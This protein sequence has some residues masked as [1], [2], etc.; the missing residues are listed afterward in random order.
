MANNINIHQLPI[1][2][3]M[4]LLL[5][6]QSIKTRMLDASGQIIGLNLCNCG[7]D[8]SF[9][10]QLNELTHLQA[11]N[12]SHNAFKSIELSDE[13]TA[14]RFV[15]FSDCKNL[16]SLKLPNTATALE[17]LDVSD[18]ALEELV[19]PDELRKLVYLDA[20][21]NKLTQ[22]ELPNDCTNLKF[23][24][25]SKNNISALRIIGDFS[26]LEYLYLPDNSMKVLHI[27]TDLP[28]LKL[29]HISNN[30]L[31]ALPQDIIL[32]PNLQTLYAGNNRP[33]NIPDLFLGTSNAENCLEAARLWFTEIRDF[34]TEENKQV[35]LMITG[36]GNTG[37]S[38]LFCAL[39]HGKCTCTDNHESTHGIQIGHLKKGDVQ[40]NVWDFG[41]QEIYHGTHRLFMESPAV[42]VIVFD[43][44]T[45][46]RAVKGKRERD[47]RS[48]E[49]VLDHVIEHW[50]DTASSLSP[51]SPFIVV[52]NKSDKSPEEHDRIR[53]YAKSKQAEFEQISARKGARI[54]NL[55]F[56]LKKSAEQLPEFLMLMPESWL[57]V[58]QWLSDNL[59]KK[60][61][62]KTIKRIDFDAKCE[63]F[64][65][66]KQCWDLLF[67]YL[68][69]SGFLYSHPNLGDT[70][71]IDQEWALT[72]IYKILDRNEDHFKQR[73]AQKRGEISAYE[74]FEIFGSDYTDAEKRLFLQFMETCGICFKINTKESDEGFSLI[75]SYLFP[76]FLPDT[77]HPVSEADWKSRT[78]AVRTLRYKLPY[79][80]HSRLL[81]FITA[82]GR[83]TEIKNIWRNGIQIQT[84]DG[85][86]R[87][88]MD[89]DTPAFILSIEQKAMTTW[90]KPI[91][92][93][94]DRGIHTEKGWEILETD[95]Q[96][97]SVLDAEKWMLK[98]QNF[99]ES[100]ATV[101][102]KTLT[103]I[104]DVEQESFIQ[105]VLVLSANPVSTKKL[106]ASVEFMYLHEQ[107]KAIEN[108]K[109]KPEFHPLSEVTRR[110]MIDRIKELKPHFI[111]FVGHGVLEEK[112]GEYVE[113]LVF[114]NDSNIREPDIL[115]T[116]QLEAT[117]QDI[118][119]RY[120][121]KIPLHTI[122]LNACLSSMQAKAISNAGF[123]V[124]GASDKII[125]TAAR[126]IAA[127]FYKTYR[128]TKDVFQSIDIGLEYA[129]ELRNTFEIYQNGT[130]KTL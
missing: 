36:N 73:K 80:S 74:M 89:Y 21:R 25:L 75:D 6:H 38:T 2:T 43:P 28:K 95:G 62:R 97:W 113:G 120:G 90:L 45:E 31:M 81:S 13:L 86:F 79:P 72:A 20:S 115:D 59:D 116:G 44:T 41:G 52:Q 54:D 39:Q 27:D 99:D 128:N 4:A 94:L 22:L 83:K 102:Q 14:L 29:L 126:E 101:T 35:K 23:I 108:E 69:H 63:E 106:S 125:S 40:F 16:R 3:D 30:Q 84:E 114:H 65:V 19:L 104:E 70:I 42:Q 9:L 107:L 51:H 111:H 123:I 110:K 18:A 50:Y 129:P 78:T 7:L 8:D 77:L 33:K 34:D 71:I 11:L 5:R 66:N 91:M 122:Y 76:E 49:M 68:H 60:E 32:S 17:R 105:R 58:R 61:K 53:K 87:V 55:E 82:L 109:C 103:K 127:G 119:K 100:E 24:D 96:I 118:K 57:N 37:K 26:A 67:L 93:I 48:E 124:I 46:E 56:L 88:A 92:E 12:L 98:G 15:N 121:D 10:S 117:F 64:K 47:R 85:W 1:L 130:K 112:E